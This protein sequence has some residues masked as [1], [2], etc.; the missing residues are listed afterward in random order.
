MS[1]HPLDPL[2]AAEIT[3]ISSL[4]KEKTP[5][6]SLHFKVIS[7]DEPPKQLLRKYL[8]AERNGGPTSHLPRLASALYYHRGTSNM[9]LATINLSEHSIDQIKPLEAHFHGQ[10][11]VDEILEMRD[12]CLKHPKVIEAIKKYQLPDHLKVVCDTWPYGRD[13]ED[14]HPRY[15]QVRNISLNSEVFISVDIRLPTLLDNH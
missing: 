6:T 4:I 5:G 3:H 8:I 7:I 14:H 2:S 15:V 11:D 13:S 12:A 1:P 9:F 10:A